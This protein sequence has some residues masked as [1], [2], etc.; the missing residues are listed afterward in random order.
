MKPDQIRT[1]L[2][3]IRETLDIAKREWHAAQNIYYKDEELIQSKCQ[4]DWEFIQTYDSPRSY[5]CKV[6]GKDK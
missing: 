5:W 2:K 4:H 1:R 3:E 6:C